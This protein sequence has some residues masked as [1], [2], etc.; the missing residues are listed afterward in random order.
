MCFP[1]AQ[2]QIDEA[3]RNHE[4]P[5][6][7][8][9][10]SYLRPR[11][12][13]FNLRCRSCAC[14]PMIMVA[15]KRVYLSRRLLLSA[16]TCAW[17]LE[18]GNQIW[19]PGQSGDDDGDNVSGE[20]FIHQFGGLIH[21]WRGAHKLNSG[22]ECLHCG[23]GGCGGLKQVNGSARSDYAKRA[24]HVRDFRPTF[25]RRRRR[26]ARSCDTPRC[27]RAYKVARCD[28]QKSYRDYLRV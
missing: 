13:A 16:Y 3:A 5:P 14:E 6:R 22:N 27:A 1:A 19:L 23:Y 21:I 9:R 24:A 10:C 12:N 11:A 15:R 7:V 17:P 4:R 26:R 20:K 18:A 25:G 2:I 8:R 28:P